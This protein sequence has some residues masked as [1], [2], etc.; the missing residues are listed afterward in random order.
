MDID[1][2]AGL[3]GAML[4]QLFVWKEDEWEQDLYSVGFFM[5]KFIYLMDAYDDIEDDRRHGHYNPW[6]KMAEEDGFEDKAEEIL[7]M[8]MSECSLAFE[9]LPLVRDRE[10]LRNVIYAGVW[11]RFTEKKRERNTEGGQKDV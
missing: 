9:R 3:T 4:G 2:A 11:T 10:L 8:M 1:H 7:N 5:G 6:L